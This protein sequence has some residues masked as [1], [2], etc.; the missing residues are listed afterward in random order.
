MTKLQGLNCMFPLMVDI[1]DKKCVVTGGGKVALRKV[2]ALLEEGAKITV[3]SPELSPE[4]EEL[5]RAGAITAVKRE[6]RE[7][8]CEDAFFVVTATND[9]ET[10]Q[11]LANRLKHRTLVNDASS[12]DKGNCHVPASLQ[13]GRL[14]LSVSTMGASPI[15]AKKIKDRWAQEYPEDMETYLDFLFN[16]RELIKKA[17]LASSD[18]K[19]LLEEITDYKYKQSPHLREDLYKLF[20]NF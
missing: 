9:Q 11:K 8:D 17:N 18:K 12:A 4:L 10:N 6:A 19:D 14:I 13:R 3:I 7:N 16:A 5:E 15:L 1:K 20:Q 2:R